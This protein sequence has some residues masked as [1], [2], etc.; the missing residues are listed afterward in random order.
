MNDAIEQ[1]P[2]K[3]RLSGTTLRVVTVLP[4]VPIIIWMMFAGPTLALASV[5]L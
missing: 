4:L 3:K 1:P 2:A 5:H